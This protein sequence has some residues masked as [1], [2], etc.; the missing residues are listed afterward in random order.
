MRP[1]TFRS[2][3]LQPRS[4]ASPSSEASQQSW[5]SETGFPQEIWGI[6]GHDICFFGLL[7]IYPPPNPTPKPQT[8]NSSKKICHPLLHA[9]LH[10]GTG[11]APRNAAG[12]LAAKAALA[13][14]RGA[15]LIGAV[16]AVAVVVVQRLRRQLRNGQAVAT[17]GPRRHGNRHLGAE[18]C[19][20]LILSNGTNQ[21]WLG[22]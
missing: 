12:V 17:S 5:R 3:S 13:T 19:Q 11:D 15:R 8:L 21:I 10:H 2:S 16:A 1:A 6:H 4:R 7:P 22:Q 9:I 20:E 18:K 14:R